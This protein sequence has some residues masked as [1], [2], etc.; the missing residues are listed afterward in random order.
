MAAFSQA[1][2]LS[3]IQTDPQALGLNTPFVA[4]HYDVVAALL[5]APGVGAPFVVF[6]NDIEYEEVINAIADADFIALTQLQTSKLG[7]FAGTTIDAT[8]A[9]VRSKFTSGGGIFTAA[10]AGT[11]TALTNVAQRQGSRAEVLWGTGFA[12]SLQQ[13]AEAH[14]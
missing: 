9:Q 13:V 7:T 5:N 10:S 6:R 1:A 11:L 14:G 8:K 3:E 4:K 12:V 2:L